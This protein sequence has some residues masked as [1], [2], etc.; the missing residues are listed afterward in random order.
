MNTLE[1]ET[2]IN[3]RIRVVYE[4]IKH[5][6]HHQENQ[7][8]FITNGNLFNG[9]AGIVY[10]YFSLLK[11]FPEGETNAYMALE[12]LIESYNSQENMA[13]KYMTFCSGLSGFY[14]LIQK[15]VEQEY[16]DELFLEDVLPINELIFEDTQRLLKDENT[17][18]LHGASGQMLYL[19]NCKNDPNR[20][21]YLNIL[22]DEL[23]KFAIID[24]KGMRFPN[25]TVKEFQNTDNINMSLSHGNAGILLVLLNIFNGGIAKEKLEKAI[26]QGLDY[27]I[28]Y[29]HPR[30]SANFSA[31]PLLV[32]EAMNTQ[33]L[34][35]G[36]FYAENYSWCYGDL[37][38]TW[39]LYQSSIAF[40]EVGYR[41]LADEVGKAMAQSMINVPQ[42]GIKINSHFCHGTSGIALFL[43]RLYHFSGLPVYKE[44]AQIWM[45]STLDHLEND[46]SKPEFMNREG[47]FGLLE[48]ISGAMFVLTAAEHED[49][50]A[51]WTDMFLLS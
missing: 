16:L 49:I 10:Y 20:E 28:H 42:S 4:Q 8:D 24:E 44:A 1:V 33:E 14:F 12:K 48:G 17:D 30:S 34:L 3:T 21:T 29:H 40:D 35:D 27:F 22:V 6:L 13:S 15:L 43:N 36:E 39:L 47:A 2:T 9:Y 23:L 5:L 37:A 18:F 19:L 31:F 25:S 51:N 26:K 7:A 11:V 45:E 50:A 32:N 38:V 41:D 46:L